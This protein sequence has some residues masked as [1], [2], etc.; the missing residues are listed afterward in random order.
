MRTLGN[1]GMRRYGGILS[2]ILVTA[3]LGLAGLTVLSLGAS[4]PASAAPTTT[5]NTT[6]LAGNTTLGPTPY[7]ITDSAGVN[8][9]FDLSTV[10]NWTQS[11]NLGTTYDPNQVRQGQSPAVLDSFSTPSPGNMSITWNI[12]NLS[13]NWDGLGP[14]GLGNQQFAASG[15]CTLAAGGPNY[16]CTFTSAQN[17]VLDQYPSPLGVYIDV[18]M[19][20]DVTVT[21]QGVA[22]IRSATL[23]GN[24]A[25]TANL[26]LTNSPTPDG[27]QVPCTTG[28]GDDLQYSLGS[29]STAPGISAAS[30]VDFTVGAE[31]LSPIFTEI[32]VP[33]ENSAINLP[34]Q[35]GS[36]PM[37]GNGAT[38]DFG[39]VQPNNVPPVANAGGPYSGNEGSPITFNGGGSSSICGAPTL[40]WNFSDGGVGYGPDPT[41][42]FEAPGT[43]TALLT[44]T[45]VTGLTNTTTF[46]VN[47]ADLPPIANAGPLMTTEW[48]LPV[49]LN[50][51][52]TDPGT[53]Q[54]PLLTYSWLFGDGTASGGA[55]A[56]HQ[57]STPGTYTATLTACDPEGMC[58][59]SST[60][61]R[62]LPR[63]TYVSY[64]GATTSEITFPTTLTASITDDQGSPVIGR[65]VQFYE[66][67]SLLPFASA[68]TN[69]SGT[70]TTTYSFPFG[71]AGNNTIVAKFAGD[72]MYTTSQDI[73]TYV[74]TKAPLTVTANNASRPYGGANPL[75][76]T[77]SGFVG[78]QTLA[79][80]DVTGS[81]SCTTP[82]NGTSAPGTYPITC[83]V[84]SLASANYSFSTFVPGTLTVT[85]APTSVTASATTMTDN[86]LT[87]RK[88][89]MTATLTSNVT[90]GTIG[91]QTLTFTASPGGESCSAVTNG[92]GVASCTVQIPLLK[93]NPTSYGAA[94]SGSTDY[95]PSSGTATVSK[96]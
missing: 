58:G 63:N 24:P 2:K 30:A 48:G 41:H 57:Y 26:S 35:T 9:T 54:Q 70:A 33:F 13:F 47:V 21:P 31:T 81:A 61:V 17:T 18:G 87:G 55:S 53:A 75:S 60:L 74:V 93:A 6:N 89:T 91:G 27:I 62:V 37:T 64:F 36:I 68:T 84:G 51:S 95:L 59:S 83:T 4:S 25:G 67:G 22:T 52:A 1:R 29:L 7:D 44:A 78:G 34:A 10:L 28:S 50:G 76:A 42:T 86:V 32:D 38:V 80:S 11:A 20:A 56:T 73:F 66:Q 45:D 39:N 72:S 85:Q 90:G 79:T 3:S 49:T 65:L 77:L 40:V 12:T 88:V 19:S 5:N 46:T 82:A 43:Y 69:T 14:F 94:F 96:P 71:T 8:V 15:A 92:S 16:D 23:G